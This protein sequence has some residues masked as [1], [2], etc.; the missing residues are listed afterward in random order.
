MS[1]EVQVSR[2]WSALT[3]KWEAWPDKTLD[4]VCGEL[5][6]H[7]KADKTATAFR[8]REVEVVREVRVEARIETV[9]VSEG[10]QA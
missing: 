4:E 2:V 6:E 1:R 9:D 8:V 3:P 5:A 7:I 10:V